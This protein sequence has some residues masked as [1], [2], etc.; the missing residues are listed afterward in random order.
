MDRRRE[1]DLAQITQLLPVHNN[2]CCEHER[3][4]ETT[5]CK[6]SRWCVIEEWRGEES[7]CVGEER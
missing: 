1:N 4:V 3:R 6:T 5:M 7:L 2:Y